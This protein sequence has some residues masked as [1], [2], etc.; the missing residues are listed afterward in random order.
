VQLLYWR[1]KAEREAAASACGGDV[2]KFCPEAREQ[3]RWE[4]RRCMRKHYHELSSTCVAYIRNKMAAISPDSCN[5]DIDHLCSSSTNF[6]ATLTCLKDNI[7]SV[8][9]ECMDFLFKPATNGTEGWNRG[10]HWRHKRDH[11][12]EERGGWKR[13]HEKKDDD[14]ERDGW[15]HDHEKKGEKKSRKEYKKLYETCGE[16]IKLVCPSTESLHDTKQCLAK[17]YI[18]LQDQCAEYLIASP[19]D[20]HYYGAA[21]KHHR[22]WKM[23]GFVVGAAILICL[24]CVCRRRCKYRRQMWRQMMAAR[25]A[26]NQNQYVAVPTTP[27]SSSQQA[28]QQI[29]MTTFPS[30]PQTLQ[31]QQQHTPPQIQ[32]QSN[33]IYNPQSV[34]YTGSPYTGI[35]LSAVPVSY[36]P[37]AMTI[38]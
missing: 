21:R 37:Q 12:D 5:D 3:G 16:D 11:D 27:T 14:E 7:K 1:K 9:S 31:P 26:Q 13:H 25:A 22:L 32:V 23:V 35:P 15:K 18:S 2:T 29:Q 36:N 20:D 38:A 24:I 33:P 19:D 34:V 17:N 10:Y 4:V 8:S 6:G 30:A 28:P